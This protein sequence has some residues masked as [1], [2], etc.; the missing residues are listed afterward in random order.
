MWLRRL[1]SK[2]GS[3]VG[4]SG[5]LFAARREVAQGLRGNLQSDFYMAL[6][7]VSMNLR[8]ISI[9]TIKGYYK[10]IGSNTKEFDR[11]VRTVIRG[12][13]VFFG[14]LFLLNP[15]EYKL[16]SVRLFSH[17]MMRWL[18]PFFLMVGFVTSLLL[19]IKSFV[20]FAFLGIQVIFYLLALLGYFFP[21]FKTIS[22]IRIPFYFSLVNLS[23]LIAWSQFI[24]GKRIVM[25]EPSRR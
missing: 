7:A 10:D 13:T 9:P 19:S 11:K 6:R 16:F 21:F 14:N 24:S 5:S 20:Y 12:L 17:K 4:L 2:S 1:E 22:F 23:I 8:A 25:W 15:F 18:V 3:V